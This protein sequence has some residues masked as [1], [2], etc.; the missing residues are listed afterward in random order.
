MKY[1][2]A[3][4]S[5]FLDSITLKINFTVCSEFSIRLL[6]SIVCV[7]K[8]LFISVFIF[9]QSFSNFTFFSFPNCKYDLSLS[10]RGYSLYSGL[11]SLLDLQTPVQSTSYSFITSL[12]LSLS[13]YNI[14][15]FSG[16]SILIP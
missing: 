1:L 9:G 8:L 5:P 12:S 15:S 16:L 13:L 3:K 4:H 6:F 2:C 7:N 14:I 10:H 11:I